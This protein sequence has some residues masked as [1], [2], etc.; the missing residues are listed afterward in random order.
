MSNLNLPEEITSGQTGWLADLE[1]L[2]AWANRASKD[3]GWRSLA[4]ELTNGWILRTDGLVLYRRVGDRVQL[5]VRNLDGTASTSSMFLP[6]TA[7]TNMWPANAPISGTVSSPLLRK[8]TQSDSSIYMYYLSGTGYGMR[9]EQSS[10]GTAVGSS[11]PTIFIWS[12]ET[13]YDWPTTLPGV[14]A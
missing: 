14:E 11:G 12:W 1:S 2:Y 9:T 10:S 6:Y 5:A 3:S 13:T 4:G 7:T 8:S